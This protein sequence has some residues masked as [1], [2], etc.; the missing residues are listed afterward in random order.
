MKS[1][2]MEEQSAKGRLQRAGYAWSHTEKGTDGKLS[3]PGPCLHSLAQGHRHHVVSANS[4][5]W[6]LYPGPERSWY[7][8]EP[9]DSPTVGNR[10]AVSYHVIVLSPLVLQTSF[11]FSP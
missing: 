10:L 7:H 1:C 11:I 4:T 8:W 2:G 5:A 6:L 3:W 9:T